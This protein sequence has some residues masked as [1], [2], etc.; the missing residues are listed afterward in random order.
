M[1]SS[2]ASQTKKLGEKLAKQI[3]SNSLSQ[4]GAFV[5]A[6][7]GELGSGKT[8]FIQGLAK[9][10]YIRKSILSPTFVIMRRYTISN[11]IW[12]DYKNFYHFDCYRINNAKEI[13][14]LGFANIVS[15]QHNIVAI[16]WPEKIKKALP[17]NTLS[18]K[19][20]HL[21]GSKREI[22]ASSISVFR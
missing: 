16:E 3:L 10:L 5:I 21:G 4:K 14:S 6:L 9:G 18:L 8:T 2:S 1:I 12:R 11:K 20:K 15:D 19:F 13:L 22:K 17:K 7:R